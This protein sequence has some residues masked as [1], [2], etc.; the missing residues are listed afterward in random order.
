MK[1]YVFP[2]VQ[3]INPEEADIITASPGT[4]TSIYDYPDGT[5]EL[6]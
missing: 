2:D 6:S 3:V 5:W 1:K 4:E